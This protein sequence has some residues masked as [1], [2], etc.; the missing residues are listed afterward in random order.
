[1]SNPSG[2]VLALMYHGLDPGDG[3]Y[4]AA[5]PAVMAY[6]VARD[7]FEAHLKIARERRR[8][9]V[10]PAE[11]LDGA[12]IA[13]EVSPIL[14]TFDDGMASDYDVALPLLQAQDLRAIFFIT[15]AEVDRPGRVTWAQLREMVAAGM[16]LGSHG[17]THRFL[18]SLSPA[19]QT[20]ELEESRKILEEKAGAAIR[21]VSLPGGRYNRHTF[22]VAKACGY[23]T[24]FTSEPTAHPRL[25]RNGVRLVG[26]VAV[27][28]GWTPE[29]LG[30]FLQNEDRCLSE[31]RRSY[32]LKAMLQA[33]LG[34]G[35]YT[36]LHRFVSKAR[37]G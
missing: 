35:L 25:L 28:A 7:A 5:D 33:V 23:D 10:E 20:S 14:L 36:R 27:R 8:K 2:R 1:M 16:A 4:G 13:P 29:Y 32:R 3:R 12:G 11:F 37:K 18:S 26:R 9:I 22:S 15:T 30:G 19:E 34:V 17:H 21:S 6:V 31:M 24:V